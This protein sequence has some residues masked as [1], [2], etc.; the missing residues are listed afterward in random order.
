MTTTR[1]PFRHD[2]TLLAS[3]ESDVKTR[4]QQ[5]AGHL[6]NGYHRIILIRGCQCKKKVEAF[7]KNLGR[8]ETEPPIGGIGTDGS[9]ALTTGK[10]QTKR[11]IPYAF[12]T[13]IRG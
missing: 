10:K 8:G 2:C 7:T 5:T 1:F 9:A 4:R 13:E 11:I 3:D 12:I 6:A